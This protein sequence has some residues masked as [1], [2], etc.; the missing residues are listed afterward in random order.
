MAED[1]F[2]TADLSSHPG[3]NCEWLI[4][5]AGRDY[6]EVVYEEQRLTVVMRNGRKLAPTAR[7]TIPTISIKFQS[8]FNDWLRF[9]G[10]CGCSGAP[11]IL[12]S[13]EAEPTQ[14]HDSFQIAMELKDTDQHSKATRSF[15]RRVFAKWF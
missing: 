9:S 2:F 6:W 12:I 7:V 8:P 15:N 1:V 14:I 10:S 11:I 3:R 5:Y 13:F 4:T